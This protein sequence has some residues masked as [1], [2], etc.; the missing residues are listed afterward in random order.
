MNEEEELLSLDRS[1]PTPHSQEQ[2]NEAFPAA[3]KTT[4]EVSGG[5]VTWL[6]GSRRPPLGCRDPGRDETAYFTVTRNGS[7][8]PRGMLMP[9][10]VPRGGLAPFPPKTQGEGTRQGAD[11]TGCIHAGECRI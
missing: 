4:V 1:S 7:P 8:L 2:P 11:M 9:N 6:D 3:E 5:G 10:V